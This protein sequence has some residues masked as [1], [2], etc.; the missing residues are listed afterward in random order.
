VKKIDQTKNLRIFTSICEQQ[1]RN[2]GFFGG[3]PGPPF[4]LETFEKSSI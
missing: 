4:G 1:K 2:I 3:I